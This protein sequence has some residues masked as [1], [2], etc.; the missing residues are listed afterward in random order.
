MNR[1]VLMITAAWPPV[2][3]V[4]AR[5]PLRL[6]RRLPALGWT[7]VVLTPTPECVF[8]R[9]PTMDPSLLEPPVEV[10]R[11]P[12]LIPSTRLDR[13]LGRLP[14]LMGRPFRLLLSDLL[15]PDQY[16]EWTRAAV[17]AAK[18]LDPVE[19]VWVTG[20]PWGIFVPGAAV[21]RALGVPLILDYRDP[22]T[23]DAKPRRTPIAVP[24]P[25]L[26]WLESR[27]LKQAAG[28]AF[29]NDDILTRT[30]AAFGEYEA[31]WEV[32]PNGFDPQDVVDV[33]P[34]RPL[35]PT[36]LYA[37]SCYAS[38]SMAPVLEAFA[39]S[40]GP[41][42]T[43][44]Q[45]RVFGEL[46]P[47][48]QR[49]LAARPMPGRVDLEGR[50][51]AAQLAGHLRGADVL[52]LI[53]GDGHRTAL[54]AKVFDYLQAGRPILGYGPEDCAAAQLVRRCGVGVWTHDHHTLVDALTR[55][56]A[57]RIPYA[58]KP[59]EIARYSADA[60]AERTAGLLD[61]VVGAPRR[62]SADPT[63]RRQADSSGPAS[64]NASG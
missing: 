62:S 12:A 2:G 45:L 26:R 10:Y 52:L 14:D 16:P 18:T 53:I 1:R 22:W 49:V 36:L 23:V 13:L 43:G 3:R 61:A 7:P 58:P 40:M 30:R 24:R 57:R 29:V 46:D 28:V 27:V 51:P 35:R 47:A 42:E 5:R 25:A 4:G 19:A 38:R 54:S 55:L 56:D 15:F 60:T 32:I 20:G 37:G 21:A 50:I 11:V 31:P 64:S 48:A 41:G 63:P 34:I 6:A 9:P 17:R 8:R 39:S 44:A 59:E 33:A